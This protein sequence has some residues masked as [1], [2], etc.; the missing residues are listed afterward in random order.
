M[1]VDITDVAR[2]C[3]VSVATVSR[4]F[5]DR[6]DVSAATR[7]RILETAAALG[8]VPNHQARSLVRRRSDTVGLIWDTGYELMGRHHPFL[9][10]V[11]VGVKMAL[12]D[13]GYHLMLLAPGL[14]DARVEG[15]VQA[16]QQHNLDGVLLTGVD[17]HHSAVS[18][19]VASGRACV[20]VDLALR[21]PAAT[22]VTSDN[23]GGAADAVRHLHALGHRR[24]ATITGPADLLPAVER[25]AGYREQL[26]ELGV[27]WRADYVQEGDFFLASGRAA[28]QRLLALDEPPTA[29]FAAGDE[30]AIGALHAALDAGLSVPRDVSIVGFDDVQSAAVVRPALT[31]VRQDT[32]QLGAAAVALLT[33]LITR[34]AHGPAETVAAPRVLPAALVVRDSTGPAPS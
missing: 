24:I 16:A 1:A 8:Y 33:D 15:Y 22:Y 30:M 23:R 25:L 34:A 5:N 21:A 20:G 14:G 27:P 9:Q 7:Q 32:M 28:M 12:A 29:V 18:T 19:L 10:D 17:E 6:P 3:G 31:T 13:A 2:E 4:A 26:A 11:L